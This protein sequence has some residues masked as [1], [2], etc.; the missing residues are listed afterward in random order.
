MWA[1][2]LEK[3]WAKVKGD[4]ESADGGFNVSGLRAV[5]GS[6]VFRYRTE[7]IG[8]AGYLSQ[9]GVFDLLT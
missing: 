9:A 6:P 1:P 7:L 8:T 2:I 4:Y 3:G 5:V